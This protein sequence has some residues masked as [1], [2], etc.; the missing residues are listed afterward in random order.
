VKQVV[1]SLHNPDHSDDYLDHLESQL[2]TLFPN[3]ALARE[4]MVIPLP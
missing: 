2:Q 4:G 1:L 3:L